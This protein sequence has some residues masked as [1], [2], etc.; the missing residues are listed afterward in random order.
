MSKRLRRSRKKSEKLRDVDGFT[1]SLQVK[2]GHDVP[3][4]GSRLS[5]YQ[6]MM[7][8]EIDTLLKRPP[9]RQF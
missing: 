3:Y 7:P 6:A 2:A 4:E 5:E 8:A 1:M 9:C